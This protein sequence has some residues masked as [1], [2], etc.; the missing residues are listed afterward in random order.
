VSPFRA[1]HDRDRQR[2]SA[3]HPLLR[4]AHRPPLGRH[5]ACFYRTSPRLAVAGTSSSDRR[6]IGTPIPLGSMVLGA[7]GAIGI[8]AAA[9]SLQGFNPSAGWGTSPPDLSTCDVPGSLGLHPPW[10]IPLPEP[11]PCGCLRLLSRAPQQLRTPCPHPAVK[12]ACA[13]PPLGT[14]GSTR[15]GYCSLCFRVSKSWEVGLPLPRLPAP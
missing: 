13:R 11:R 15:S 2:L 9:A 10:G 7:F 12:P 6:L 1:L 3:G 4:L 5:L 14:A 8:A